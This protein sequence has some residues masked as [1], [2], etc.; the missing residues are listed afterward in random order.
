MDYEDEFKAAAADAV[1]ACRSRGK[2]TRTWTGDK[3]NKVTGWEL[4]YESWGPDVEGA[5]GQGWWRERWGNR[6]HILA[7]DGTF[8]YHQ[9]NGEESSGRDRY[10]GTALEPMPGSWLVGDKGKPY[11]EWKAKIERLPYK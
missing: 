1:V 2:A 8:W 5:P 3:G 11:S 6:T 4:M 9:F 10:M 7:M